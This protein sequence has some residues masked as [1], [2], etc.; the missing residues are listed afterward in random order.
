MMMEQKGRCKMRTVKEVYQVMDA[1]APF[2]TQEKWDNSGLLAGDFSMP[3]KKIYVT[4]DISNE[5]IAAAVAQGADLMVAH[6]PIIFSP[7]KQLAPQN[8]VW[9]LAANNLAAICS[10]TPLDC[11]CGGINDRLHAILQKPLQL[12]NTI[13]APEE[14]CNGIGFGWADTS[15]VTWDAKTL[16]ET[17]RQILGC[18]VV[19]Y[20]PAQHPIQ[21]IYVG[22]GSCASMLEDA[23][24]MGCDAMITGDVKH[25]RWY[26][27]KNL[28]IALFD[29][30]HYHTEQIAVQILKEQLQ[31]NLPEVEVICDTCGEPVCYAIGGGE[32]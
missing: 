4:L 18:T 10:H 29:C 16:A 23:A 25:D 21:K 5:T 26:A 30:G 13:I 15:A 19:R 3:V 24:A 11:A 27:A 7:L 1:F 8:P 9:K 17:L 22:C 14:N 20:T 31:A 12:C 32:A 28:D 2:S 6:H